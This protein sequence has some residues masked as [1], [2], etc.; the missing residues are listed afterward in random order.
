MKASV[1]S[2]AA[3]EDVSQRIIEAKTG[4]RL[5]FV[6]VADVPDAWEALPRKRKLSALYVKNCRNVLCR[7]VDFMTEHYSDVEELAGVRSDHVRAF[8]DS[9]AARCI[10]ARTWNVSLKLLKTVFSKLEPNADAYRNFLRLESQKDEDTIHRAP[11][12][13]EETEAILE[14]AKND[15]VLRGPLV[16]A[17]CTAM[18]KGDCCLLKWSSVDLEQNYIMVCTSKTGETAEIPV[19]PMKLRVGW[20]SRSCVVPRHALRLS[21]CV[22]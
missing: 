20:V 14:A 17:I 4:S 11:F 12:T 13:D 3:V 16:V 9:E 18:R 10:S 1:T 15:D 22:V 21:R 2:K 6:K 8:L 5:D 19:M 7:F